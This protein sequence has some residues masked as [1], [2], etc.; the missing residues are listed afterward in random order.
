MELPEELQEEMDRHQ[1]RLVSIGQE[2]A[3]IRSEAIAARKQSGFEK[4]W[5]EDEEFYAGID[6]ANRSSENYIKPRSSSGGLQTARNTSSGDECTAFVNITRPFVDAASARMGDILLPANDWNF[7]I[8]PTPIPELERLEDDDRPAIVDQN[9]NPV[10]SRAD[11][12]REELKAI[13]ESVEKASAQ[14]KDW[15]MECDYKIESRKVIDVCAMVGTGIMKGPF[16]EKRYGKVF[17]EGTLIIKEEIKP[18]SKRI[19][20][21]DFF[22]D[23]NCGDSIHD[24]EYVFERD[25][26]TYQQLADLR[27]MPGS[28]YIDSAITKVLKEGPKSSISQ[29]D[30]DSDKDAR[31]EVWYYY[32]TLKSKDLAM[33]DGDHE[34]GC[35]EEDERIPVTV[36]LVNETVIKGHVNPL[37]EGFP[38]DVFCWQRVLGHPFGIGVAR[39]GRTAQKMVLAGVRALMDNMALSAIPMLG[40]IKGAVKSADGDMKL[41]KGKVWYIDPSTGIMNIN[42]AIQTLV[43]P[44]MQA[45]M[46][47][48]IELGLKM[49]EDSTGISFL[50]QGQQGS[51]PDTV[52]GMNLMHQNAS[53]VLRR[54]ARLFDENITTPHIKRYHDFLLADPSVPDDAKGDLEIE[55]IGSSS[56]VEREIQSMQL[57]QI[58]QLTLNPVF[59]KSPKK[60]IDEI[61]KSIK[62]DPAKFDMD[63]E[64]KQQMAEMMQAQQQ[65]VAPQVQA[66]QIRAEVDMQKEQLRQEAQIATE[67]SRQQIELQKI[68]TDTDRDTVHV[69]SQMARDQTQHDFMLAKLQ[70]ERELAMLKYANERQ[71]TLDKVKADL[72]EATMKMNL[73]KELAMNPTS[74]AEQIITPASE[75]P[76]RAAPGRAF[77]E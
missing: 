49:M 13:S 54:C 17:K 69:Q 4:Q 27:G 14:I 44:P 28:G 11:L 63:E 56:L 8:K 33:I 57:P 60:A 40:I 46:N 70:L 58:L 7:H 2:I 35:D 72:A 30:R 12:A 1:E 76:Q 67:Q 24:G 38:F 62:F 43:I 53:S 9:G 20:H 10:A 16:P 51:A 32:G 25:Y 52:G 19:D 68:Q 6:D 39:Q 22:P 45:E 26:L 15:L 55:A 29:S 37:G 50:L 47:A 66:A 48:I 23:M 65:Q 61:L 18:A 36:V 64:E 42:D 74:P 77:Q 75:P 5:L 3:K 31:F 59:E 34:C 21:W 73:Q 41:R 71:V